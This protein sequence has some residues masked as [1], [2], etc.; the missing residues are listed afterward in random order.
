VPGG[1][2]AQHL[3][4]NIE[5]VHVK[6]PERF[7]RQQALRVKFYA[8]TQNQLFQVVADGPVK[9]LFAFGNFDELQNGR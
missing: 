5:A 3:L 6:L 8:L 9:R 7:A 1:A 2:V 4:C